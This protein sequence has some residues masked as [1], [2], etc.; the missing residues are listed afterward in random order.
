MNNSPPA[1]PGENIGLLSGRGVTAREIATGTGMSLRTAYRAIRELENAHLVVKM[2]NAG[3]SPEFVVN[4]PV[5]KG[6]HGER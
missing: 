4:W 6:S 1:T 5:V 3:R 2:D